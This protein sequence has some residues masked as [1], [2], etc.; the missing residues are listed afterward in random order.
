MPVS[1]S[2]DVSSPSSLPATFLVSSKLSLEPT[3]SERPLRFWFPLTLGVAVVV[4]LTFEHMSKNW[5][6]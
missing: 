3:S 6:V 4:T 2:S 1:P 5:F